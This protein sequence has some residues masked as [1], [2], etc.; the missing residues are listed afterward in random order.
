MPRDSTQ[1]LEM[2]RPGTES[3]QA[4]DPT[5]SAAYE[6][7]MA[8]FRGRCYQR[9]VHMKPMF[10]DFD[11]HNYGYVTK[12]QFRQCLSFLDLNADEDEKEALEAKYCDLNGFR[13]IVFLDDVALSEAREGKYITQLTRLMEL[14][15]NKKPREV[16]PDKDPKKIITRLQVHHCI[17]YALTSVR[18]SIVKSMIIVFRRHFH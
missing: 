9:R 2:D 16:H 14:N 7:V 11:Q 17:I 8:R 4:I 6:R 18:C 1:I 5:L 13:Y 3:W 15:A 12:N 10:Q